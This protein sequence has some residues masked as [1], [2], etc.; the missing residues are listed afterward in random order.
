MK[1]SRREITNGYL[2]QEGSVLGP[3]QSYAWPQ[4]AVDPRLHKN[5]EKYKNI[6]LE[7]W[8][9]AGEISAAPYKW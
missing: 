9:E 1:T 8:S 6:I 7:A 2:P 4:A 5:C 3:N